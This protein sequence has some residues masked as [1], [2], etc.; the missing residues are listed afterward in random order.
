MRPCSTN[1][2]FIGAV[3]PVG[4]GCHIPSFDL[5]GR[6]AKSEEGFQ[7]E[8]VHLQRLPEVV[9]GFGILFPEIVMQA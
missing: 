3:L 1:L 7:L 5:D 8:R 4:G 6:V 9:D 2:S